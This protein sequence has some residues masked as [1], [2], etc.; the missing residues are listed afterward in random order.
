MLSNLRPLK[1]PLRW[2]RCQ[3]RPSGPAKTFAYLRRWHVSLASVRRHRP[4][5]LTIITHDFINLFVRLR[6]PIVRIAYLKDCRPD[7]PVPYRP[8]PYRPVKCFKRGIEN[9]SGWNQKLKIAPIW[10]STPSKAP[11][12]LKFFDGN[13]PE[14]WKWQIR[15][16]PSFRHYL[17]IINIIK[18][19]IFWC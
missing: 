13:C 15:E 5:A 8:V 1:L 19:M 12:F 17:K 11:N 7:R 16:N 9:K 2:W 4:S 18:I 14:V 10:T 3:R 6:Y